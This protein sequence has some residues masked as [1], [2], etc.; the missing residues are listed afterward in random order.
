M[1]VFAHRHAHRENVPQKNEDRS[2]R[3]HVQVK[4]YQD[5][6]KSPETEE[7]VWEPSSKVWRGSNSVDTSVSNNEIP[8]DSRA[9]QHLISAV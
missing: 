6:R 5:A 1:V 2:P 8:G 3:T 7:G 4:E 9:A